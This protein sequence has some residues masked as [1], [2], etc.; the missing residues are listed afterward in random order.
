MTTASGLAVKPGGMSSHRSGL[1]AGSVPRYWAQLE[2]DGADHG[3]DVPPPPPPGGQ[4][5]PGQQ[6]QPAQHGP[7]DQRAGVQP[8]RRPRPPP[9]GR[10]RVSSRAR[11]PTGPARPVV[12]Q[13]GTPPSARVPADRNVA[14]VR[15]R[16]QRRA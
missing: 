5:E 14:S 1:S 16:A 6:G 4:R 11:T 12:N 9:T 8:E 15:R 7:G 10:R 3:A 13:P 2:V